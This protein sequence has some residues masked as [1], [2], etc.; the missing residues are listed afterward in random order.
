MLGQ[1]GQIDPGLVESLLIIYC[2][3]NNTLDSLL[4]KKISPEKLIVYGDVLDFID[5]YSKRYKKNPD[6]DT[7]L[8][9]FPTFPNVDYE[10]CDFDFLCDLVIENDNRR[11]LKGII[12][13][14]ITMNENSYDKAVS[15]AMSE[16]SNLKSDEKVIATY[17][18]GDPNARVDEYIKRKNRI[19]SGFRI[20]LPT[21]IELLDNDLIGWVGGDLA[22]IAGPPGVG[23]SFLLVKCCAV[24]YMS[25]AKI[26]YLTPEMSSDDVSS[27]LDSILG[28]YHGYTFSNEALMTG[29]LKNFDEYQ[30]YLEKIGNRNNWINIDQVENG[31]F[32]VARIASLIKTYEPRVVAMD[33]IILMT[34]SDGSP[35]VSWQSLI[36]V[37][38]GLKMLAMRTKTTILVTAPTDS[39]TFD[40]TDPAR[41]SELGLSKN[42]SFALDIGVSISLAHE[43]DKRFMSLFKKRK[44][45]CAADG[46]IPISFNPDIG[47]IGA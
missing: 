19:E 20:G 17:F 18:D 16:L 28:R 30:E 45:R 32:T 2:L 3:R 33:S 24:S 11:N 36:D 1:L 34:A 44:G 5:D 9:I 27:R 29:T 41:I 7:L 6:T 22:M 23:K 4:E 31:E 38:Y 43:T 26:L 14:M 25:G 35:A 39:G 13:K 8:T 12:D 37:A 47:I 10:G 21:G 42:M 40:S 15:F 46:K